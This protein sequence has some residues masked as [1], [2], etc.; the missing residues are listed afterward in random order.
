[1]NSNLGSASYRELVSMCQHWYSDHTLAS[2]ER[3]THTVDRFLKTT[4]LRHTR[5]EIFI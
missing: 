1:M 5:D 3:P 2:A 4:K